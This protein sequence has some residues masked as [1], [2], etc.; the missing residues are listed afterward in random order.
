[1]CGPLEFRQLTAPGLRGKGRLRLPARSLSIPRP[2]PRVAGV[3]AGIVNSLKP[4]RF[5][6]KHVQLPCLTILGAQPG[7]F[8]GWSF[9][10]VPKSAR[11]GRGR[12][13][14]IH[15]HVEPRPRAARAHCASSPAR[16]R[17]ADLESAPR[18]G[19]V[20]PEGPQEQMAEPPVEVR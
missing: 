10:A 9:C 20:S 17:G 16:A 4:A 14:N 18:G 3:S 12:L 8:A 5:E 19:G 7:T 6:N 2:R 11:Q 15:Q 1:M 13:M